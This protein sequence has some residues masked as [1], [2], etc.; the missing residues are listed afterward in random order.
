MTK[1]RDAQ[2]QE[3]FRNPFRGQWSPF[4]ERLKMSL[5]K[6]AAP[7]AQDCIRKSHKSFMSEE[8]TG[9]SLLS[10][11]NDP[12]QREVGG[13]GS[14]RH[15]KPIW[16]SGHDSPVGSLGPLPVTSGAPKHTGPCLQAHTVFSPAST[17]YCIC[18]LFQKR[19]ERMNTLQLHNSSTGALDQPPFVF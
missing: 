16:S 17:F 12:C 4:P 15:G 1:V 13:R 10:T 19:L 18:Y 7:S 2:S 5:L 14:W 11:R 3:H 6:Q 8:S 9:P